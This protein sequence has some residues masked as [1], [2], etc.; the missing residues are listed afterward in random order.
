MWTGTEIEPFFRP[1]NPPPMDRGSDIANQINIKIRRL[2]NG[3]APD[4]LVDTSNRLRTKITT[5]TIPGTNIGD[6]IRFILQQSP[7]KV[8]YARM[9]TYPLTMAS[10]EHSV[11]MT[12]CS[13]PR[14]A[15]NRNPNSVKTSNTP[16]MASSWAPAPRNT[17]S[18]IG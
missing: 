9:D 12:V 5:K 10:D 14:L 18:S 11:T 8:L 17:D 1:P 6:K 2:P 4:E 15:G 16:T 13:D 3:T 7:S